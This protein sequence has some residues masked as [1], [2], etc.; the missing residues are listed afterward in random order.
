MVFLDEKIDIFNHFEPEECSEGSRAQM[1]SGKNLM[2]FYCN[3][4]KTSR[5]K[6]GGI[7][8]VQECKREYYFVKKTAVKTKENRSKIDRKE[9]EKRKDD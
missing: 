3:L 7:C 1:R 8:G 9:R 2:L 6:H 4:N 5:R